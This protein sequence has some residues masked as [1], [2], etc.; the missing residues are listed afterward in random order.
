MTRRVVLLAIALSFTSAAELLPSLSDAA[1][2]A[3]SARIALINPHYRANPPS[4]TN[5]FV[6]RLRELGYIEGQ[7]LV[8]EARW[9]DDQIERLPGL[10]RDVIGRKPDVLVTWGGAAALAAKNAPDTVPIVAVGI[11]L[12]T[13]VADNLARPGGNL[14]GLSL[15]Y[16]NIAGK[17]LELLKEVVPQLSTVAVLTNPGN[18]LNRTLEKSLEASAPAQRVRL[19]MIEVREL[20]ALD[21]AF[22]QARHKA[23]AV[24]VLPDS[25]INA[26]RPRITAIAA[27]HR[28]PSI[29]SARAMVE[30]GGLMSYGPDFA[31][32]WRRAAE[33]VDKILKG[34]QPA[35]L[36]IEEPTQFE[37]VVNIRAA[38]SLN[39]TVPDSVLLR[40][41]FVIR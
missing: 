14:T 25:V 20:R 27:K 24:V 37:L 13:S 7:N 6:E 4:G 31:V 39:L 3:P 29:Y 2:L 40:A 38:K 23:Q 34:A 10:V 12:G 16:P 1:D 26:D 19:S 8:L 36:P 17:W 41:N 33:Y 28:L 9:A 18:P 11:P 35:D 15:G 32:Q 21:T 22:E 5:A 30:A